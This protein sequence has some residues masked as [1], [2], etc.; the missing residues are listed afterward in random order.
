MFLLGPFFVINQLAANSLASIDQ[1]A[2]YERV[3]RRG[4]EKNGVFVFAEKF[5]DD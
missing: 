3:E 1:I 5:V 2:A 4:N